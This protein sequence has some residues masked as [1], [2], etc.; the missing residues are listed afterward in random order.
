[1]CDFVQIIEELISQPDWT[2][3]PSKIVIIFRRSRNDTS[4]GTTRIA[5]SGSTEGSMK[6]ALTIRYKSLP[7]WLLLPPL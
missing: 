3:N 5:Q 7:G 1:L 6:P 4:T 2:F